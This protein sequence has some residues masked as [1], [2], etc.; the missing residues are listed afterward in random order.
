MIYKQTNNNKQGKKNQNNSKQNKTKQNT[1]TF[2]ENVL[3][4]NTAKAAESFAR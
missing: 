3:R 1:V 2:A 4:T